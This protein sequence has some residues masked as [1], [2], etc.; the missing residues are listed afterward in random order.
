SAGIAIYG[1]GDGRHSK[2][3]V[4]SAEPE[5]DF[6]GL[7]KDLGARIGT[8]VTL[9]AKSTH[10][11]IEVP[12]AKR[13]EARAAIADLRPN[14]RVMGAGDVIEIYKEV[15]LPADVVERFALA[16]MA[17]THGIGHTRMATESA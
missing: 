13:D 4:Q 2:I 11:V 14:I 3:T 1:A 8:E 16:S 9:L 12:S 7:D 10:A 17:G 15:G 5:R 6:A